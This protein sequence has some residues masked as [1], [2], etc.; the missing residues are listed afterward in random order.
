[1]KDVMLYLSEHYDPHLIVVGFAIYCL[2]LFLA[3]VIVLPKAMSG[4]FKRP[5]KLMLQ[6]YK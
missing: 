1:M 4:D 2:L 5:N 3:F 6:Q